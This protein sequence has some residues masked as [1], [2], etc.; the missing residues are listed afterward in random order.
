MRKAADHRRR[1][2]AALEFTLTGV[3][4]IFVL[5]STFE[6]ARGMWI[7]HTLAYAVKEGTRYASVHGKNCVTAPNSCSVTLGQVAARI[8]DNGTGLE[9]DRLNLTFTTSAGSQSCLL[10][11]CLAS[12]TVWPDAPGNAAGMDITISALY[13]FRSFLCLFWPGAGAVNFSDV[14]NFPASSREKIQF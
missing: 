8:R 6:M 3:P 14:Y 9:P 2:S 4:L 7:Y 1:G 12:G 13:P 5:I 10:Q 11:D